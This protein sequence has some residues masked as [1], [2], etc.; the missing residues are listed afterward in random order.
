MAL[1]RYTWN[2]LTD[3]VLEETDGLGNVE[4]TYTNKPQ[5]YAPLV[6]QNRGGTTSHY[7]FDALGSSRQLTDMAG[8]VTDTHLCDAWGNEIVRTGSTLTPY[9]W[10]GRFG[11]RL[12]ARTTEYYVRHR[13]YHASIGKWKSVDPLWLTSQ[14]GLYTYTRNIAVSAID[15]SGLRLISFRIG[16]FISR[17]HP[18]N[19][20]FAEPGSIFRQFQGDNRGFNEG[21]TKA[22]YRLVSYGWV[23]SCNMRRLDGQNHVGASHFR[24]CLPL[25]G[26]GCGLGQSCSSVQTRRADMDTDKVV[27]DVNRGARCNAIMH[28]TT[29]A[30][31][32]SK[33]A[34]GVI[35]VDSPNID[36][37]STFFFEGEGDQIKGHVRG[38]H[39]RFPDYEIII[40]GRLI[41][42]YEAN[43]RGPGFF[44]LYVYSRV[45]FYENFAF[46]AQTSCR[47][48][49]GTCSETN[50][51]DI[52][53]NAWA[54]PE[55]S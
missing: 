54:P 49:D 35:P 46:E 4:V 33:Y 29:S 25:G 26:G 6:S 18:G 13:N 20:W 38:E 37:L 1:T 55:D 30:G 52:D 5:P 44:N 23:D 12:D 2:P 16:A 24:D 8:T 42:K 19:P 32:P 48:C 43:D 14:Q 45:K 47:F 53:N 17:N 11:Y 36:I 27:F 31:Y 40:D 34:Y 9:G 10:V 3:G 21:G 28:F 22:T 50:E 7:H 51:S 15:P 41:Y 39:D